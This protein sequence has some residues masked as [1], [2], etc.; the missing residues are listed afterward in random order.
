MEALPTRSCVQ[1]FT[2]NFAL[3]LKNERVSKVL[4]HQR[5]CYLFVIILGTFLWELDH[6]PSRVQLNGIERRRSPTNG[7][8]M[9]FCTIFAN[10]LDS[11]QRHWAASRFLFR[12][13]CQFP[14][15]FAHF[16][17]LSQ[18]TTEHYSTIDLSPLHL[19]LNFVSF[20]LRSRTKMRISLAM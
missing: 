14:I 5:E 17:R 20:R 18:S 2:H 1:W 16:K 11:L 7:L 10:A 9:Q 13:P 8:K 19:Q 4:S 3:Q 15:K 12:P 6:T